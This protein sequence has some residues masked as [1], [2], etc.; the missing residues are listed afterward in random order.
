[1]S[2]V[3][4]MIQLAPKKNTLRRKIWQS[5]RILRRFTVGDL[6]RTTGAKRYNVRKFVKRLERHGYIVQ[7]GEYRGGR[8]GAFRGLRLVKDIGP[9]YPVRCEVCGKGLGGP[10]CPPEEE[11]GDAHAGDA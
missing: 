8:I 1:M 6:C 3:K 5:M 7:V 9:E 2:G 10:C 11:K 4:G